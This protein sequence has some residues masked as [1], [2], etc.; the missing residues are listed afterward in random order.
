MPKKKY[1]EG[2]LVSRERDDV[3]RRREDRMRDDRSDGG[4]EGAKNTAADL[5]ARAQREADR[6]KRIANQRNKEDI[7]DKAAGY[8]RGGA[9]KAKRR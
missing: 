9:V 1:A 3:I 5:S 6:I 4:M 8:K 7:R 2:G